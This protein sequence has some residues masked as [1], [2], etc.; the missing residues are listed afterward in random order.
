MASARVG[1]HD[2]DVEATAPMQLAKQAAS[3]EAASQRRVGRCIMHRAGAP[4]GS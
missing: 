4:Q 1:E 3:A 2:E